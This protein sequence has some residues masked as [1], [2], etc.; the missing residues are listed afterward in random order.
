M[1]RK[2]IS[3]FQTNCFIK[4]DF[5]NNNQFVDMK[6]F[7]L[8]FLA[9]VMFGCAKEKT[10]EEV[11]QAAKEKFYA[12]EQV[13]FKQAMLIENPALGEVDTFLYQM[14]LQKYPNR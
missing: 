7:L 3:V 13:S 2:E 4:L 14:T 8:F 5:R 6:N 10:P 11:F 9:L 12:A 1:S